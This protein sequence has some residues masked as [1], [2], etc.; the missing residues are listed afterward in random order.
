LRNKGEEMEYQKAIERSKIPRL[1]YKSILGMTLTSFVLANNHLTEE[2]LV[3]QI[4]SMIKEKKIS[5]NDWN[6][7]DIVKNVKIS[8]SARKSEGRLWNGD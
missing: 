8:V 6:F 7:E 1:P 3:Y 5:L 2:E 4:L